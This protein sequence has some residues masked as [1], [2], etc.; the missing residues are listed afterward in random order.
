M[1]IVLSGSECPNMEADAHIRAFL[2]TLKVR[3]RHNPPVIGTYNPFIPF[4]DH[5][6]A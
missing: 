4:R 2:Q 5:I 3:G 6:G 1:I